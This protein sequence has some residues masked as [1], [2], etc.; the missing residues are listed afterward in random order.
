MNANPRHPREIVDD[1]AVI[2]ITIGPV[3]G[4]S[5]Y[6]WSKNYVCVKVIGLVVKGDDK[7]KFIR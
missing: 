2:Y 6:L 4:K 5:R 3:N 1:L 7:S